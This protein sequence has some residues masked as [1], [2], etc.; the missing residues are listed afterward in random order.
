MRLTR[1]WERHERTSDRRPWSLESH[2]MMQWG[3]IRSL[4]VGGLVAVGFLDE[5]R[6]VVGSHSGLGIVEAGTGVVLDRIADPDGMYGWYR[7]SPPAAVY[8]DSEGEHRVPVASFWGRS[9]PNLHQ[10]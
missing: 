2:L 8:V 10:G 9:P 6:V 7:E 5:R 3:S 1:F 4:G